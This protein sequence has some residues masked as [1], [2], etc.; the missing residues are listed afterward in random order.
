MP[1]IT[2]LPQKIVDGFPKLENVPPG[3]YDVRVKQINKFENHVKV[4]YEVTE[5][6]C[7]G[8][9]IWEHFN[10]D[11]E[12][13][14]KKFRQFLDAIRTIPTHGNFDL[15]ACVGKTLSITVKHKEYKGNTYVNVTQHLPF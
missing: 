5:G 4:F 11:Y 13:A 2:E 6:A 7:I 9:P 8:A 15:D 12:L 14:Q 3:T 1:N 10:F